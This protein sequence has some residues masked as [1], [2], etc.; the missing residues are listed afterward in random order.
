VLQYVGG[1][2][3][4]LDPWVHPEVDHPVKAIPI[5]LE[6]VRQ[7][8]AVAGAEPLDQ[9][10]GVGRFRWHVETSSYH[11]TCAPAGNWAGRSGNVAP[12]GPFQVVD[13]ET[14]GLPAYGPLGATNAAVRA[15]GGA[16]RGCRCGSSDPGS[17]RRLSH[18]SPCCAYHAPTILSP[19]EANKVL[20]M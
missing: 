1:V 7:R 12:G 19:I 10:P 20:D 17:I 3:P 18:R 15:S 4:A 8:L 6:Q 11:L 13:G 2:D 16:D 14:P 9:L 5:M